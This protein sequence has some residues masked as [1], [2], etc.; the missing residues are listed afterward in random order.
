MQKPIVITNKGENMKKILCTVV[1][2]MMCVL[3]VCAA[4]GTLSISNAEVNSGE[5]FEIVISMG[6]LPVAIGTM[7]ISYDDIMIEV[8]G[9]EFKDE[10]KAMSP[11]MNLEYTENSIKFNWMSFSE[12]IDFTNFLTLKC[13]AKSAGT[14]EIKLEEAEMYD[15]NENAVSAKGSGGTVVIVGESNESSNEENEETTSNSGGISGSRED[16]EEEKAPEKNEPSQ[17]PEEDLQKE[18]E[19]TD[20]GGVKWAKQAI[21]DLAKAG[22]INGISATEFAPYDNI[23]RCDY[24]SLIVRMLGIESVTEDNFSDVTEDKYYYRE[25]GAAKAS[26]LTNGVGDNKFRPED[27]INRESMFV[28]IYRI[29]QTRGVEMK[30]ADA[31]VLEKFKDFGEVSSYAKEAIAVLCEN[32]IVSG[33]DGMVMPSKQATRAEAAVLIHKIYNIVCK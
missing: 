31:T 6:E 9:Y 8:S 19:F 11:M 30:E 12:S 4:E 28:L 32:G 3:S 27:Y 23:K 7:V 25:I 10:F 13:M 5:E 20:I 26:G 22:V 17:N 21:T 29:L 2:L 15:I 1:V 33:S 18:P 16:K 24:V 14:S